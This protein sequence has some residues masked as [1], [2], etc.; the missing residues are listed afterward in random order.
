V[1]TPSG[2]FQTIGLEQVVSA[3]GIRVRTRATTRKRT[4]DAELGRHPEAPSL[5]RRMAAGYT[6]QLLQYF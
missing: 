4:L 1:G 6:A 2:I 3:A 5:A